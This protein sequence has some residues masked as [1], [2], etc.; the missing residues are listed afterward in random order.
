MAT[1]SLTLEV[2][3]RDVV[4]DDQLQLIEALMN[5]GGR[6]QQP[7]PAVASGRPPSTQPAPTANAGRA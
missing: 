5:D 4:D 1:A 2:Y 6:K 3:G 7:A